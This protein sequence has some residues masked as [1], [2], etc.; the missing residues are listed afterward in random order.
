M[1]DKKEPYSDKRWHEPFFGRA[2]GK[3]EQTEERAREAA[4]KDERFK[5]ELL[6]IVANRQKNQST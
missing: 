5:K 2:I 3:V 4:E 6:A 1:T